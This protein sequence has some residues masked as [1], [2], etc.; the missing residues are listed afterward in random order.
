MDKPIFFLTNDDGVN[1]DGL[2]ALS[3]GLQKLGRPFIIAPDRDNSAA[4]HSLTL[5]RPLTVKRVAPDMFSVD[6]TPADCVTLGLTKVLSRKP[7]ILVS[8]INP[9]PNLGHDISYSGTVSAAREGAIRG[10]SSIAVSM[11][12]EPPFHYDD[13]VSFVCQLTENIIKDGLPADCLLNINIPNIPQNKIAGIKIT[14]QGSRVYANS[15]KEIKDPWGKT[16]YWIG[17]GTPSQD[18]SQLSDANAVMTNHISITPIHLDLT[19]HQALDHLTKVF[20][21]SFD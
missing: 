8:G 18:T 13:A 16:R 15:I 7:S 4:S 14:H 1:A 10:V 11:A 21:H 19:N 12:G 2:R 20:P 17:G 6:G 5:Q 3:A 9:G